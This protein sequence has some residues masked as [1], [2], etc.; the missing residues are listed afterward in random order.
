MKKLL[1]ASAPRIASFCPACNK[2]CFITAVMRKRSNRESARA[3]AL[4]SCLSLSLLPWPLD[5]SACLAAKCEDDEQSHFHQ[6]HDMSTTLTSLLLLL[7]HHSPCSWAWPC[8][9][10]SLACYRLRNVQQGPG[11]MDTGEQIG[12]SNKKLG[13]LQG[14]CCCLC[15]LCLLMHLRVAW[16]FAAPRRCLWACVWVFLSLSLSLRFDGLI[17]FSRAHAANRL[18]LGL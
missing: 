15:Q 11:K 18:V 3:R 7:R 1:D 10:C 6:A 9:T 4:W 17:G 14:C 12:L 5:S 13:A 2:E 8:I 16:C